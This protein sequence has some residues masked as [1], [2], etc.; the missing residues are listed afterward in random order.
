MTD[1]QAAFQDESHLTFHV[2]FAEWLD[3]A[4]QQATRGHWRNVQSIIDAELIPRAA[5]GVRRVD[6]AGVSHG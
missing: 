4:K 2:N 6:A 1:Q 3:I 5:E